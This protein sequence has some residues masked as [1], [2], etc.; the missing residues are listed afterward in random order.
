MTRCIRPVGRTCS[1]RDTSSAGSAVS[2]VDQSASTNGRSG[3][4]GARFSTMYLN[5][6]RRA[7]FYL[8]SRWARHREVTRAIS[9][10]GTQ[11]TSVLAPAATRLVANLGRRPHGSHHARGQLHAPAVDHVLQLPLE[12]V[13]RLDDAML[14]VARVAVR[15]ERQLGDFDFGSF[16]ICLIQQ[17]P[18]RRPARTLKDARGRLRLTIGRDVRDRGASHECRQD[19]HGCLHLC[20][21]GLKTARCPVPRT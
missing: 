14:M 17:D 13:E 9:P 20:F 3:G 6:I 21:P 12:D 8:P 18:E 4:R 2:S 16:Q 19:H 5:Q 7:P 10:P 1:R 11:M 15:A